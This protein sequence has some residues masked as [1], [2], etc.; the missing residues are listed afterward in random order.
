VPALLAAG[1]PVA[2]L[3]RN[4]F[5]LGPPHRLIRMPESARDYAASIYAALREAD[6]GNPALIAIE[7]PPTGGPEA[8]LWLA[9]A[10]RLA[11]ATS[12]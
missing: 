2:L 11:R 8:G 12:R 4:P 6:T 10:D 1:R 3:A 5:A 7:F 9:I